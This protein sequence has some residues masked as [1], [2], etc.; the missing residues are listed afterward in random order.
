MSWAAGLCLRH[1]QRHYT[2]PDRSG[3]NPNCGAVTQYQAPVSARLGMVV[4]F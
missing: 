1:D 2:T 3:V 4:D